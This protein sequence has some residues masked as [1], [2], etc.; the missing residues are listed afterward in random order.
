MFSRVGMGGVYARSKLCL[1]PVLHSSAAPLS[2]LHGSA[3]PYLFTDVRN[4]GT[5]VSTQAA[6]GRND[7]ILDTKQ[8]VKMKTSRGQ[9][10]VSVQDEGDGEG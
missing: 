10:Q 5:R 4:K 2:C 8:E 3:V 7:F 6:P 9:D 1:L